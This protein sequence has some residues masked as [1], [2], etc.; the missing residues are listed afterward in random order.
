MLKTKDSEFEMKQTFRTSAS[1]ESLRRDERLLA[2]G[3]L[4]T[5][6]LSRH[7]HKN[8]QVLVDCDSSIAKFVSMCPFKPMKADHPPMDVSR[9]LL[10]ISIDRTFGGP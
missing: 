1:S 7:L 9:H 8:G 10:E 3:P 6:S 5:S 2:F 4:S